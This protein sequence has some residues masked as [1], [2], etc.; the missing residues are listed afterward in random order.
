MVKQSSQCQ[1]GEADVFTEI[2]GLSPNNYQATI[3]ND[4]STVGPKSCVWKILALLILFLLPPRGLHAQRSSGLPQP[5]YY[6]GKAAY[7]SGKFRV[8]A[9]LF[10]SASSGYKRGTQQG[11]QLWVDAVCSYTMMAECY[12]QTGNFDAAIENYRNALDVFLSNQGWLTRVTFPA[13][14]QKNESAVARAKINW[15]TTTRSGVI[16]NVNSMQV[17]FGDRD[18]LNNIR[19]GGA[20]AGPEH[21]VAD[22]GEIMRCAALALARRR[23]LMGTLTRHA[24]YSRTLTAAAESSVIVNHPYGLAWTQLIHGIS[25]A[26]NNEFEK[27]EQLILASAQA[28]GFDHPL[29]PLALFELANI[30]VQRGNLKTAQGLY[31]EASFS[32]AIFEQWD[33]LSQAFERGF[34][35]HL[36]QGGGEFTP[37]SLILQGELFRK[38]PD[39]VQCNLC[40][41]GAEAKIESGVPGEALKFLELAKKYIDSE[42]SKSQL[43]ARYYF[44]LAQINA[45]AGN[46]SDSY[47]NTALAVNT[48]TSSSRRLFQIRKA[49]Q[50]DVSG[51]ITERT[52]GEIYGV[53]LNEPT[54]ADW[55][56]SPLESLTLLLSPLQAPRSRWFQIAMR[57][58]EHEKAIEIA[59][60]IRRFQFYNSMPLGGRLL[61]FRWML[62]A[63]DNM[64][65]AETREQKKVFNLAFP[66]YQELSNQAR[67]I[68]QELEKINGIPDLDTDEGKQ[69][70]D[71]MKKLTVNSETR[72]AIFLD[73]ALKRNPAPMSFPPQLRFGELQKRMKPKQAAWIFFLSGNQYFAFF[74]TKD[75]YRFDKVIPAVAIQRHMPTLLKKMGNSGARLAPVSQ[76]V[77]E[78]NGWKKSAEELMKALQPKDVKWENFDELVIVPDGPLWYL[79]FDI[80]QSGEDQDIKNLGDRVSIRFAPTVSTIV[81]DDRKVKP[82]GKSVVVAGRLASGQDK[83]VTPNE[84]EGLKKVIPDVTVLDRRIPFDSAS[85]ASQ[86]D[87]LIVWDEIEQS[88]KMVG[89]EWAPLQVDKDKPRS[90]IVAW[91]GLPFD[92]PEQFIV[93]GYHT[94]A[95]SGRIR[96]NGNEV[97]LAVCGMMAT[98]AR[99]VL[100]SRWSVGG[101]NDYNLT[102]NF[103]AEIRNTSAVKAWRKARELA[104]LNDINPDR[105]PRIRTLTGDVP[106][107]TDHPFF[108]AGY[109]LIDTGAEPPKDPPQ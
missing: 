49:M 15:G 73:A 24:P 1:H 86:I 63:P 75:T 103:A 55:I 68:R 18:P 47:A 45:L 89:L 25:R 26:A 21:R 37:L 11:T 81:P 102:R 38:L 22:V 90:N 43:A 77:L 107:K 60:N 94:Q 105:E 97:F 9:K 104:A 57:R 101:E 83:D 87:T 14:L 74:L 92:G 31:Q 93:P 35:V 70:L 78:E 58:K 88:D 41:M 50:L 8:A 20:L 59:D 79:P 2:R 40:L 52:A 44:H 13:T 66:K 36:L 23:E 51:S 27:A 61:A 71:L 48:Y 67:L 85:Y 106:L 96:G 62:E 53:L 4:R 72:D 30:S 109:L 108:W 91:M 80:L 56:A 95:G 10:K 54:G 34:Q 46:V 7:N 28:K 65:S 64:I 82:V 33:I 32:A 17:L 76:K 3:L 69:Q 19:N 100:I 39:T 6:T 29:T 98:G 5:E 42:T 99:T 84:I 16:A 12:Y